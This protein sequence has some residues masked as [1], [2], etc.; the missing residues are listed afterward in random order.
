MSNEKEAA[1]NGY[2]DRSG[3]V[4][5]DA[6]APDPAKAQTAYF[7]FEAGWAHAIA[8]LRASPAPAAGGMTV[9]DGWQLVPKEPTLAMIAALGFNGDEDATIGH[10]AISESVI[11]TYKAMLDAAPSAGNALPADRCEKC[12]GSTCPAAGISDT[13]VCN[14]CDHIQDSTAAMQ[15]E[16]DHGQSMLRV[17]EALG[18]T[19]SGWVSPDVVLM[20]IWQLQN[21]DAQPADSAEAPAASDIEDPAKAVYRLMPGAEAH[22][23]VERGNSLKQDEARSYARAALAAHPPAQADHSAQAQAGEV[24]LPTEEIVS[25]GAARASNLGAVH[26]QRALRKLNEAIRAYGNARALA[27]IASFPPED[28]EQ[29]KDASP[30]L[31]R[32]MIRFWRTQ[33]EQQ[34]KLKAQAL[35]AGAGMQERDAKDAARYRHDI[36]REYEKEYL[37]GAK[38][39]GLTPYSLEEYKRRCDNEIDA[40]IATREAGE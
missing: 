7:A 14:T 31:L 6:T 34:A 26:S 22:P 40:A 20:R 2:A 1:W 16:I 4:P 10:A 28:S 13:V 8:H 5:K 29:L 24:A 37:P 36:Q 15:D 18:F 23:W 27:A 30:A 12:G 35:A 17:Q 21:K 25:Y 32:S 11:N 33:A 38:R 39:H 3:L 9:P 19:T